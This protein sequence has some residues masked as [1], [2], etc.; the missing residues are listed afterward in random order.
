[1]ILRQTLEKPVDGFWD[2]GQKQ[3]FNWSI[4]SNPHTD[5]KGQ[6]VKIGSWEANHWFCVALG[7]TDKLTLAN[8]KKHLKATTSIP[9]DFMYI[10]S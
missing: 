2:G 10:D 1:M 6:F 9:S 7:R 5:S 4:Q 8:A 3:Q